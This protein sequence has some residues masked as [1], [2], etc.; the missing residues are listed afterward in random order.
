MG[1]RGLQFSAVGS[2]SKHRSSRPT[3]QDYNEHRLS[4]GCPGGA[5]LVNRVCSCC[6]GT[7]PRGM[8]GFFQPQAPR[9]RLEKS[10]HRTFHVS[11]EP[12]ILKSQQRSK[13]L[14][15]FQVS[16]NLN[17]NSFAAFAY[18]K[19]P[20]RISFSRTADFLTHERNGL[21]ECKF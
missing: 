5:A 3:F 4:Q 15:A 1:Q 13:S 16:C 12:D 14:K 20:F 9:F 8:D 10:T 11:M 7:W 17:F 21:D 2:I 18:I 19:K 6:W